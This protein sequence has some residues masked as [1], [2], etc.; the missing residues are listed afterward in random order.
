MSAIA[1]G[2]QQ[3]LTASVII[4][5]RNRPEDLRRCLNS[6]RAQSLQPEELVI[7]D[8]S[9]QQCSEIDS[10]SFKQLFSRVVYKHTQP[11][12]TYQ[13]NVG[14]ENADGDVIYFFDDDVVLE[15]D[16]LFEM[17]KIFTTHPEYNGGM[18]YVTGVPAKKNNLYRAVQTCFLLQKDNASGTFTASGMPTHAY[19]CSDFTEVEVLGGCCMAYRSTV[20]KNHRF[21]ERLKRYG[22]MEDC[23]F[24]W[25][26]SRDGKLFYNPAARLAHLQSPLA[27]DKIVDNKAMF[28]NN[29]TYLFFKNFYP[30]NRVKII[31]YMWS[32]LGL[33][34]QALIFRRFKDMH[35]YLIGLRRYYW[36]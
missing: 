30:H 34:V 13:R 23:D 27:R 28:I 5:T 17:Q 24:S 4:C 1:R 26:V 19:G 6:I 18:G 14:I 7:I 2:A 21:D 32:V 12:L 11:G 36:S 29:Y 33:F 25:R 35:G 10:A 3:H 15:R 8:G 9:D 31:L 20:F 16:Y 22:Y